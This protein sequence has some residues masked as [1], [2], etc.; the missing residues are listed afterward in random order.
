MARET[1]HSQTEPKY[2]LLIMLAKNHFGQVILR[3]VA[4]AA[5][6]AKRQPAV[7]FFAFD[8]PELDT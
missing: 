8:Q 3:F 4:Y 2:A 5:E 6:E 7:P 1:F